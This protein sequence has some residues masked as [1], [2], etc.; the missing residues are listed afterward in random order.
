MSDN[1]N[2]SLTAIRGARNI[3]ATFRCRPSIGEVKTRASPIVE[4]LW[5]TDM[6]R[7]IF[8]PVSC[9]RWIW[10]CYARLVQ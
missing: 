4:R 6:V 3:R 10:E 8:Y 1:R 7:R 2:S 9:W 5:N